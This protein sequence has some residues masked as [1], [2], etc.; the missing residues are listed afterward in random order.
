MGKLVSALG[1]TQRNR[2]VEGLR[3]QGIAIVVG[4]TF[5]RYGLVLGLKSMGACLQGDIGSPVFLF[6][7]PGH[8]AVSSC[9][10]PCVL[11]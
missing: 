9:V 8:H 4:R 2:Y 6:Q 10:L 5:K 1:W 7:L 3:S 11:L